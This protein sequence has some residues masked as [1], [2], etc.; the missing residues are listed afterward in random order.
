RIIYVN[1]KF[2]QISKYNKEDIIGHDHR[3]LNSG[4]H[5]KS[6]FI[7]L[8]K[9]ISKGEIWHG[10][11]KNKAK[12]GT[13]YWVDTTIYPL[14]NEKNKPIG[15]I[16]IRFDITD[17]K[18]AFEILKC[19]KEKALLAER[20]KSEFLY[21]MSH[22][23]RTPL[24]G[25]IGMI[26]LLQETKLTLEQNEYSEVILHSGKTLL[27]IINDILDFSKIESGKM[28][29]DEIEFDLIL[30]IN[31][32]LK[33]FQFM[34][35]KKNIIFNVVLPKHDYMVYGDEGK[36]GQI[37]L[38]L[39]SNAIKFTEKGSVLIEFNVQV[40]E[41]DTVVHF[42]VKDTGHG[43]PDAEKKNIFN[44]FTQAEKS[45]S[46]KFGG[47]GLGL[48]IS[49]RLV[50][51]MNGEI[52][53]ESEYG[54]GTTFN[55]TL[56]LKTG[57]KISAVIGKD[58]NIKNKNKL[59]AKILIAEDNLTNQIVISRILDKLGHDYHVVNNGKEVLKILNDYKFDLILMDCQ[60]P[61]MDGYQAAELI[62]KNTKYNV[63]PIV[64]LTANVVKGDDKKCLAAGMN[65]YITKPITKNKIE[66]VINKYLSN[67][68]RD[69]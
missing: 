69:H 52:N 40:K 48:S 24:N 27:T 22:E 55:V 11:I 29:L 53:F 4:F 46:R 28:F 38:N 60:M 17:K 14:K 7:D 12:D 19:S 68:I 35:K 54:K 56:N 5:D 33:K 10:E 44:A 23:I 47:T 1:D 57:R 13:Y 63:I 6:F 21:T 50:D 34:A 49:K 20:N 2:I 67:S 32:L 62:R 3:I 15:Y 58:E 9:T 8:W 61:E 43:I 26:S 37:L 36:I 41:I 18:E 16:A 65:D 59:S 30:Y 45:T 25:I 51:L 42:I 39:V 66:E 64:A 31:N